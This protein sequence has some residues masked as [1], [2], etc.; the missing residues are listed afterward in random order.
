MSE[1]AR[2]FYGTTSVPPGAFSDASG[3]RGLG[4]PPPPPRHPSQSQSQQGGPPSG[5]GGEELVVKERENGGRAT[6][7]DSRPT[8]TPTAGHPLLLDG[9][10][11]VYPKHHE[12]SKCA[13]CLYSFLFFSLLVPDPSFLPSYTFLPLARYLLSPL[14][15]LPSPLTLLPSPLISLSIAAF[16]ISSTPPSL[17]PLLMSTPPPLLLLYF[18]H[19][20]STPFFRT[21]TPYKNADPSVRA[22]AAGIGTQ[23]RRRARWCMRLLR[24]PPPP[25]RRRVSGKAG[26]GGTTFQ[27][28]LPHL[29]GYRATD[30]H[31]SSAATYPGCSPFPPRPPSNP[32]LYPPPSYRP[33]PLPRR[34]KAGRY[35]V[36][37]LRGTRHREWARIPRQDGGGVGRGESQRVGCM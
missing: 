34:P 22:T 4:Y 23:G 18:L 14:T 16:P 8:T 15:L 20:S 30:S 37:A 26:G 27:R 35:S 11:L 7:D 19:P 29:N 12:C 32:H 9:N 6:P 13:S 10:M 1:F 31:S 2:D 17:F 5:G 28:P 25:P 21:N 3:M 36:L 24:V 33:K